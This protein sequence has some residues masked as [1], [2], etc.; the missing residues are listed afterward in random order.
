MVLLLLFAGTIYGFLADYVDAAVVLIALAPIILVDIVL[1]ARAERALEKLRNL[2]TPTVTVW[3]DSQRQV[4]ST[5]DLVPGDI[6][7]LQ[8]G[9][10]LPAD[11]VLFS[12]MQLT[13][14]ESMLT[15]ES[16]PVVKDATSR[17]DGRQVFAG[18]TLLNGR[19]IMRVATIGAR[20]RYGQI[21]TLVAG[22]RQP[23]TPLQQR[24]RRLVWQLGA[25]AAVVCLSVVAVDVAF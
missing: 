20:T 25:V 24:I 10:I 19:G 3:R 1:E 13:V 22:I 16:Q 7:F 4:I 11:G 14:D 15:G 8:E 9:D 23:P 5:E 12:G 2:A 18:T 17:A 21:G 6:V